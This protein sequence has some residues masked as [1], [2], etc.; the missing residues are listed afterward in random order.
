MRST[1]LARR[2]RRHGPADAPPARRPLGPTS[3]PT[4]S[5]SAGWPSER[6]RRRRPQRLARRVP[7]A[8]PTTS[9]PRVV[10]AARRGVADGRRRDARASARTAPPSRAAGPSRPREAGAACGHAAAAQHLPGRRARRCVEHYRE[11]ARAGLPIV[12]Y[13]NPFDTKVDLTPA[14]LAR[15]F[16]R[17]LIVAV[18]EFTGD[19]R[20]GVRDRR[21]RP[22]ARPPR[23]LR[24]RPA[25]AG[26]RRR[27]GLGRRLPQRAA[28]TPASS[29]TSAARRT[30][31]SRRR[32]RSTARCTR[33]CAGT[34]RPSSCRPSS[35]RWTS[36]AATA[37]PA[38]PPR[39]AAAARAGGREIRAA[40]R[41][42]ARGGTA[43]D[44]CARACS[45]PSTR[46][47]RACRPA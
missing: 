14:L 46:T 20:A 35:C 37:A 12:A 19:V 26:A 1:A 23:R 45:T 13:N 31:T 10:R 33:C 22:R 21:A 42:G 27:G 25:R 40:H 18:K 3:T 34:P 15:L 2:P 29:S 11:V 36:P 7:D 47:P 32:C 44:A 30:A 5:T 28:P 9:A 8:A 4:P 16:A 43:A 17:G 24:R 39:V 38:G 6:L 41:E